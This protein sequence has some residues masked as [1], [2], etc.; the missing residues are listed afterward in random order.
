MDEKPTY[1]ELKKR[2]NELER[3]EFGRRQAE[4]ALRQSEANLQ[5]TQ[6]IANMGRWDLDLVNKHLQWSPTIFEIFEIDPEEFGASYEAFLETIHP[7]D[8]ERVNLVYSDS[9]KH[10]KPYNIEH[11]LLMKDGRIKWVNEICRTDYDTDGQA[12]RSLGIVQDITERKHAEEALK[13]SESRMKI[14]FESAPDAYYL[15]DFAGVFINGNQ[16]AEELLGYPREELIGKS[17]VDAGI[18]SMDQVE[19]ALNVLADNINGK[20]TGP[21]KYTLKRKDGTKVDVEILTHPVKIGDENRVLGIARDITYRKQAE[22]ELLLKNIVFDTSIVANSTAD[23]KGIIN[24]A[25]DSFVRMWGYKSKNEVISKPILHFIQDGKEAEA[26]ISSLDKTGKWVGEYTARKKDGSTFIANANATILHDETGKKVGYQSSVQD[27]TD[28][29]KAEEML[30][31]SEKKYRTL[32]ETTSEGCWMIGPERKTMEVNESLCKM[33]GYSQDEIIGKTPFDFVDDENRKIFVE[34]TSKISTTPHRSYEITLKKKNGK[35]LPTYFNATTIRDES[36]VVQGSFALITDV[37]EKKQI[38]EERNRLAVCIEQSVESVFI[39][40]RDGRI[41]YIN[42]AFERVTGYSREETIGQTPRILKSGKHDALFYK[43]MWH[44]LTSGNTWHGRITNRKKDGSFYETEATISPISD[45][46]GRITNFVSIKRDITDQI[47][48]EA[49]LQ[50]AQKME[51]IGALA[52]GVAHDLNNVLSGIVSYPELLLLDLPEDSPLRKPIL[53][54][55]TSGQKAADIVQDLLTLARRGVVATEVVNL[56]QV[57]NSYLKSPECEKLKEFHPDTKIKTNLE[58]YLLNIMGS[59][60]HLSKTVMNLVSN[61]TKAMP[62]GGNIFISTESR[63]IDR[64]I[65]GYDEVEE[66][67]YVVLTVSDTGVGIPTEDLER[68]FEPFYTKKKM[69]RSGTGLGMAV[70]W[71]TVKDHKGYIDIQSV[72]GKGTTFTFFF[73]V[74][75]K[76]LAKDKA[77]VS[78][79]DY[80][81]KGESILIV[82]DVKEQ[83]DIA[84]SILSE[85]GYSVSSVSSGEEAVEYLKNYSADLLLLDMI[86]DPEIDGLETYKRILEFHPAQKAIIASGFS[87]TDRVKE[88]QKLGAGK[89]IKK[90]Y[91]LE[92]IGMAVKNELS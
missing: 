36:G 70:V 35:D 15:N 16:A 48:L 25:N 58:T 56:N 14:I 43:Q 31:E 47:A 41:Q 53:T 74:T 1:E 18:L 9:L 4:E 50:R 59:S 51:A 67:D 29:K 2:V 52:G 79:K 10:Q 76:E 54:I 6:R 92:K 83:R 34:Q 44:T 42:P 24:Q 71:G 78:I 84:S 60:V 39:T 73:P 22:R 77:P 46:S 20:S 86:M 26:I 69:G 40:D 21:D 81:G 62:D 23:L 63:Y 28:R 13:E 32:L 8:R 80:M 12:I 33:L 49:Q 38:E 3:A 88:A 82:D 17:F 27:I 87:E 66:G 90:P 75:R 37:T 72:E 45:K 19:K 91:T 55:Q 7:D 57:I 5:E 30:Q 85:L 89:Y 64:P 68:I 11:R 65:G 61:A